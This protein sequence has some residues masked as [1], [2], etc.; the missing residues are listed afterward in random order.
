MTYLV[1]IFSGDKLG[2]R[3]ISFVFLLLILSTLFLSSFAQ[4]LAQGGGADSGGA[5]NPPPIP[6]GGPGTFP[7]GG[8]G[9][10]AGTGG[11][12]TGGTGAGNV[13]YGDDYSGSANQTEPVPLVQTGGTSDPVLLLL[14]AIFVTGLGWVVGQIGYMFDYSVNNFIIGF[15]ELYLNQNIGQNIDNLWTTVRDIFNL[16]FIFGLVYIGFKMILD[17]SDSSARKML[18]SLIGAALLVNFSLFITKFVVDFSNIAAY[19]IYTAFAGTSPGVFS[20]TESFKNLMGINEILGVRYIQTEGG[21]QYVVGLAIVLLVL[22][23]VFLAGALMIM[24]RFVVLCI[25]MVFSPFMFLGW[26]FPALQHYSRDYWSGFLRQAFFAPAFMFMLYLSYRVASSFPS[27]QRSFAYVFGTTQDGSQGG[28]AGS[29]SAIDPTIP[30]FAMVIVFLVASIVV[31]KKMGA[32]GATMTA[33]FGKNITGRAKN[34]ITYMPRAGTR[35]AVN[36]AGEMSERGLNRLQARGGVLGKLAST[37]TVDRALRGAA[38]SAS[39][40]KLGTVGSNKEQR[41]YAAGISAR[42]DQTRRAD[43]RKGDD[44]ERVNSFKNADSTL[45]KTSATADELNSAFETLGKTI[46]EMSDEQRTDL[47]INKLK[48]TQIAAHLTDGHIES[49]EKSGKFSRQ[50]ISEIKASRTNAFTNIAATGHSITSGSIPSAASSTTVTSKQRQ[51]LMNRSVQ[52]IAKMPTE[53]FTK[54]A[55]AQY[56]TPQMVEEKMKT[57]AINSSQLEEIRNNIEA[58]VIHA[59]SANPSSLKMWRKWSDNTVYGAQLGINFA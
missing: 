40:A 5:A 31:A 12:A 17:S 4:V 24:I 9:P 3:G 18:V 7:V 32:H 8:N 56:L 16:T 34:A 25:Y 29:T 26:V 11:G 46:K 33:S 53:V 30:F 35:M 43:E 6:V 37:N 19:Q 10:G 49:L 52:D 38:E 22:G 50:E 44:I 28:F 47:G 54:P 55:M 14:H 21:Y 51:K 2:K 39:N 15:G 59:T 27:S 58:N 36:K 41:K 57:G 45:A 1:G 48:S 42:A 13:P 20:L 23:Y